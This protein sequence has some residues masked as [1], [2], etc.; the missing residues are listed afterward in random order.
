MF[1]ACRQAAEQLLQDH[2]GF[3]AQFF[4]SAINKAAEAVEG[5]GADLK[6]GRRKRTQRWSERSGSGRGYISEGA[7]AGGG[8]YFLVP[9][10]R[11]LVPVTVYQQQD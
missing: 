3:F 11:A 5:T 10:E 6:V 4:K 1:N 2:L 7:A 8:D 9:P